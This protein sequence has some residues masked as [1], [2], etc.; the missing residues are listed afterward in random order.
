[1]PRPALFVLTIL[2]ALAFGGS[3]PAAV[4]SANKRT[5]TDESSSSDVQRRAEAEIVITQQLLKSTKY[6]SRTITKRRRLPAYA[7]AGTLAHAHHH[8]GL[9]E[10]AAGDRP[11]QWCGWWMRQ[12]L[13]GY[14]GPEF[15]VARNWLNVGRALDGPRPGAIGVKPHHVFQ[16]IRVI[17]GGHVL[18]ISGNDHNAVLTRV[19]STSDVVGWR[20][21][22]EEGA[23]HDKTATERAK[24]Q[25]S[26]SGM[27]SIKSDQT[28]NKH[29]PIEDTVG[30]CSVVDV[31]PSNT[32]GMRILGDK[33]GYSLVQDAQAALGSADCKGKIDRG[34]V[35]DVMTSQVISVTPRP[36][37]LRRGS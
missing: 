32:S 26:G 31:P 9:A 28:T 23:A 35:G 10:L 21:V 8:P 25:Q 34:R 29:F 11:F 13:G 16:V 27:T 4:A 2:L 6:N 18:A 36:Q 1:M 30:N 37:F 15:N 22:A 19:R 17:D 20:D 14:Y 7:I 3:S 24:L 33:N 5:R 12:H